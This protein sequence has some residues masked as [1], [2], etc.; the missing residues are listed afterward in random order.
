MSSQKAWDSGRV[1]DYAFE[2]PEDFESLRK[3]GQID[4]DPHILC[5]PAIADLDRDNQMELVVAVSY[6]FDRQVLFII[7]MGFF[8][9]LIL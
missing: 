6:F 3:H 9:S 4:I 8:C 5:T 7:W 1:A 2:D